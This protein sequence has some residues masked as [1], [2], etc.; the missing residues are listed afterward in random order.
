MAQK[1]QIFTVSRP[2]SAQ[3]VIPAEVVDPPKEGGNP[4]LPI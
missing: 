2:A 3:S 1:E 4:E